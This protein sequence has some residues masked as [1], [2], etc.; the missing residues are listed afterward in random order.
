MLLL[1]YVVMENQHKTLTLVK[2]R[3]RNLLSE[4]GWELKMTEC[5]DAKQL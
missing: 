5:Y 3:I 2:R 4:E 1:P